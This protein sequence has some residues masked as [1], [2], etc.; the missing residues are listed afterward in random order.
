MVR[1]SCSLAAQREAGYSHPARTLVPALPLEGVV[2][3][4]VI[5]K[6]ALLEQTFV[7]DVG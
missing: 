7:E 2:E 1:P 5:D 3:Q 4:R 6:T